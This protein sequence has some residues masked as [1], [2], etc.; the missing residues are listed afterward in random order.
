MD[1]PK[2][3]ISVLPVWARRMICCSKSPASVVV[4]PKRIVVRALRSSVSSGMAMAAAP[5]TAAILPAVAAKPL[6]LDVVAVAASPPAS[7]DFRRLMTAEVIV[8]M[9]GPTSSAV[10]PMATMYVTAFF[11]GSGIPLNTPSSLLAASAACA[12]TGS[13]PS[14]SAAVALSNCAFARSIDAAAVSYSRD[15]AP[16]A[17]D[18][19]ICSLMS[20]KMACALSPPVA[21]ISAFTA[22][23]FRARL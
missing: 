19:A 17:P 14:P 21:S 2:R 22:V 8:A 7:I 1:P 4:A 5:P 9:R 10:P 12:M 11:S 23:A 6:T 13:R 3:P 16:A 15:I 18:L 20:D